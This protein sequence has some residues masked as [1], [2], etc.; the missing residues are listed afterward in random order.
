[1]RRRY[2]DRRTKPRFEVIGELWGSFETVLWLPVKD[3]S[4]TGALLQS[5]VPLPID[6][7]H[8]VA[9]EADGAEVSTRARVRHVRRVDSADGDRSFLVGVEFLPQTTI[10]LNDSPRALLASA[11]Q[12]WKI[13]LT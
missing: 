13:H 5:H 8:R 2:P 10:A 6:S 11:D 7:V 3:I 9:Y 12:P 4:S 1:M